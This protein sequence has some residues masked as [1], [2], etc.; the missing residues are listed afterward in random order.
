MQVTIYTMTHCPQCKRMK[1]MLSDKHIDFTECN[2]YDVMASKGIHY[3]PMLEVDGVLMD[4][5]EA[6][7]YIEEVE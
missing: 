5:Q 1:E 2:D 6:F 7:R 4:T 3:V